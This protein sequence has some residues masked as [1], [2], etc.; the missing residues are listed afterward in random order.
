MAASSSTAATSN[1]NYDVFLSH[2]GV[3]VKKT[4]ASYL[5]LRLSSSGEVFLDLPELQRGDY[6]APQI[7]HAIQSA[8]VHVAILSPGYA[9]SEWCLNELIMMLDS[10]DPIIPVFYHVKPSELRRTLGS[11]GKALDNLAKKTTNEGLL[12]EEV[13]ELVLSKVKKRPL[14]VAKYPI[15]LDDKVNDL[16]NTVLLQLQQSG[17]PQI[18]GILGLGG[19]GKTTLAKE[20]FNRKNPDYSKSCFLD[21][22][23]DNAHKG[24][25]NSLQ[26]KLLQS[27]TGSHYPINSVAQ[28]IGMLRMHLSCSK[29]LVVLDDV[30]HVD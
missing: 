2:R 6:F 15:G 21:D 24:T 11:Y 16:E 30:D 20:I 18:L 8:S 1:L 4:F 22:V 26:C 29:A 5:Y 13:V 3:D 27:L 17:K 12:L 14:E 10:K 19:V 7:E 9:D 25:L 28:G 23:R